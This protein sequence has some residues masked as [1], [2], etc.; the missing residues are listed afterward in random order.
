MASLKMAGNATIN[1][2]ANATGNV[3]GNAVVNAVVNAAVNATSNATGSIPSVDI[4]MEI[5]HTVL[6]HDEMYPMPTPPRHPPL[7]IHPLPPLLRPSTTTATACF[8]GI[9]LNLPL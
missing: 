9:H 8:M 4:K 2:T 5:L 3:T 6:L 1:A 7:Q